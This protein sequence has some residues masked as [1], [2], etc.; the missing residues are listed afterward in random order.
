[1]AAI[2][3]DWFVSEATLRSHVR[4]VLGKLGVSSQLAAVTAA[5]R[6]GWLVD[7]DRVPS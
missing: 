3:A 7:G 6:S 4:S 1:V 5:V 2:A